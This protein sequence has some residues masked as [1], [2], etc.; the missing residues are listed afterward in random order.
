MESEDVFYELA[1]SDIIVSSQ[2]VLGA[3]H[4]DTLE[5]VDKIIDK[6]KKDDEIMTKRKRINVSDNQVCCFT[7][8]L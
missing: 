1:G 2:R 4:A 8:N 6:K 7:S 5:Q 3:Q